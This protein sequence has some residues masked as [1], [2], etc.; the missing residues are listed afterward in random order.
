[1]E[2]SCQPDAQRLHKLRIVIER[3]KKL[4]LFEYLSREDHK[5]R[6]KYDE[7]FEQD[8]STQL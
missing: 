6:T 2:C 7:T 8:D 4:L 5:S 1:M 3:I